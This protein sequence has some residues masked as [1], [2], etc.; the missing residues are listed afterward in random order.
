M[1]HD[2]K[3]PGCAMDIELGSNPTERDGHTYCC[4]GCANGTGCT[5]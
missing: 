5:C 1:V 3:C 4:P 2:D